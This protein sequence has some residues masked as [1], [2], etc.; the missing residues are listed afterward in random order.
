[1][2]INGK[3]RRTTRISQGKRSFENITSLKEFIFKGWDEC[4]LGAI[5]EVQKE[6]CLAMMAEALET[7]IKLLLAVNNG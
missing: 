3:E 7:K 6:Q 4:R 1:M 5:R 2:L